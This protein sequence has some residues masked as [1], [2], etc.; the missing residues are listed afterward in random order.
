M[1]NIFDDM[2]RFSF[3]PRLDLSHQAAVIP[4]PP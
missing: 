1:E 2:E 4:S 3:T